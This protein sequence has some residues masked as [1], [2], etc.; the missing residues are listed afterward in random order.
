MKGAGDHFTVGERIAFYRRRRGMTQGVLAGLVGRS[1]DWLSK[2]E[3]NER[4]L[5]RLDLLGEV[6]QALRIEIGDLL[7][8]PVLV[9]D[10]KPTDDNIPAI[11]DA[12]MSHRRLSRTLFG[13]GDPD[14]VGLSE[15]ATFA[16]LGWDDYQAG[17]I[18]RVIAGLPALIISAQALEETGDGASLITAARVYHLGASTLAKV[19]ES[20]LSWIAAERAMET[21]EKSGSALALA[22][23]ARAGT[24]ALLSVGRFDDAMQLGQTAADW[25]RDQI[26][27]NDAAGLSIAGMLYLRTAIASARRQDRSTTNELLAQAHEYACRLGHD[28]NEW[29][30]MFG[31]TNVELH[32]MHA[33]LD[34]G[35]VAWVVE[36]GPTVD[37]SPLNVERQVTRRIDMARAYAWTARDEDALAEL[38]TAEK[39]APQIV[40][41]SAVVRDTVKA[42]HRRGHSRGTNRPLLQLADRCRAIQ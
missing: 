36:H 13:V 41:H 26:D 18:G 21:A 31:P 17:R 39:S 14:Q 16:R 27:D 25:L 29:H 24:H 22:S 28:S 34:L 2:I 30:T 10:E 19:G 42:L 8:T 3:R 1:V 35:D 9:E 7:G 5:R 15:V 20:D 32:R 11:R 37:A 38:L 23:S 6:A 40:R 33:A 12:L 4:E